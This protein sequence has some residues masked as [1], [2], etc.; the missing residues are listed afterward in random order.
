LKNSETL[1]QP[2]FSRFAQHLTLLNENLSTQVSG[3]LN[4]EAEHT[5][6]AESAMVFKLARSPKTLAPAQWP[7]TAPA[8]VTAVI[9]VDGEEQTQ[10]AA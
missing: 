1:E 7:K 2:C 10:Q 4:R 6:L 5:V 3:L 9:F 8:G